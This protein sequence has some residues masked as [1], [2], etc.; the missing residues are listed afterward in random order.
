MTTTF[1]GAAFGFTCHVNSAG[2]LSLT[3]RSVAT[4]RNVSV[5][6][7]EGASGATMRYVHGAAVAVKTYTGTPPST[8]K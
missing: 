8:R 3:E 7:A 5:D 1:C 4:A 6:P 2:A